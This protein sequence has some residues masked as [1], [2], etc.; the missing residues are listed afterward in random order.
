[1]N[2]WSH[3]G[4]ERVQIVDAARR[5][6]LEANKLVRGIFHTRTDAARDA[7]LQLCVRRRA[8]AVCFSAKLQ[9]AE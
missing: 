6:R 4:R 9:P 5:N 2:E 1:M 3:G 7:I 8:R